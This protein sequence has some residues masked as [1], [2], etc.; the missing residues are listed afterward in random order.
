MTSTRLYTTSFSRTLPILPHFTIL[1][2]LGLVVLGA[3]QMAELSIL[4]LTFFFEC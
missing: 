3:L 4:V 2:I 1:I